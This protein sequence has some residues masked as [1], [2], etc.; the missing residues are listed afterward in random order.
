M[1][2]EGSVI[3]YQQI[4]QFIFDLHERFNIREVVYD[5]WG[6]TQISQDLD[7][8]GFTVVPFGQGFASMS[9]PTKE[10]IKHVLEKRIAH[11]GNKALRWMI[12]NIF[13]RTDPAGNIKIDKSKCTEKVDGAVALVMGL[14]RAIRCGASSESVYNDRG[15]IAF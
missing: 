11:N 2:T 6:A 10:L 3:H 1:T 7:G 4:E 5:R 12:D 9:P 14:D 8:E 15:L 13:I